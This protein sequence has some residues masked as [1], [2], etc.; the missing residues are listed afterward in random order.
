M[1]N[2]VIAFLCLIFKQ[3]KPVK[4]IIRHVLKV[5]N[6]SE[7]CKPSKRSKWVTSSNKNSSP[8]VSESGVL[9]RLIYLMY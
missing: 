7:K 5:E 8:L 2:K 9:T 3:I 6:I 1:S 4:T